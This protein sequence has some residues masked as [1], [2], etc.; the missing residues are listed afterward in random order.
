MYSRF[1]HHIPMLHLE[2]ANPFKLVD[3]SWEPTDWSYPFVPGQNKYIGSLQHYNLISDAYFDAPVQ[4]YPRLPSST[5][6]PSGNFSHGSAIESGE[7]KILS[8]ALRT[9][10]DY[11]N[12]SD[13]QIRVSPKIIVDKNKA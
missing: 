10:G 8:R 13:W 11:H 3:P 9:Y 1:P 5:W 2:A 7:Y 12:V 4:Q 6:W